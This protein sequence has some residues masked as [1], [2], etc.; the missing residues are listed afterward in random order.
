MNG[1]LS[2]GNISFRMHT[3]LTFVMHR[4]VNQYTGL[5]QIHAVKTLVDRS[6]NGRFL[7]SL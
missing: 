2:R 1:A 3:A 5:R 7:Q 6:P 4:Q